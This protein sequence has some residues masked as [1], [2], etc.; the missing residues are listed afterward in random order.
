MNGNPPMIL[1][2]IGANLPQAGGIYPLDTCRWAVARMDQLPNLR[3][4]GLSRWFRT[5]PQPASEQ[6]AYVNGVVHL[7]AHGRDSVDPSLLLTRLQA[8]EQAAGRTRGVPNAAR[9]LDLDIIA[10]GHLVRDGADL[11]LPHPRA[12][13]RGFVLV[14]LRDVAPGW[15]HPGLGWDIDRLIGALPPQEV[16]ALA[17]G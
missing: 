9:T 14:P 4:R 8:I 11:L 16:V 13:Q 10:V 7:V 2:S 17:A 3:V 5:A 15:V 1:V 6:A 12:H